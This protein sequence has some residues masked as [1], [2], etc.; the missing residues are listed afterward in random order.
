MRLSTI[1]RRLVWIGTALAGIVHLLVPGLL[2]RTARIGYR[3]TLAVDF[4]PRSGARGRVRAVG[5]GLLA[6]AAVVRRLQR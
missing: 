2:L 3:V 6:L 1:E 5:I 4:R